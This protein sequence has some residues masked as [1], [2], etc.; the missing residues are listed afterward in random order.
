[1]LK[2]DDGRV[3]KPP[4]IRRRMPKHFKDLPYPIINRTREDATLIRSLNRSFARI[5]YAENCQ[6]YL[7]LK[8]V[9]VEIEVLSSKEIYW[10]LI[11]NS[12]IP[13]PYKQKWE[14]IFTNSEIN[15]NLV[16]KNVHDNILP[17]KVQSSLWEMINLNFICSYRLQR[18]YGSPTECI[19]CRKQEEGQTHV[20]IECDFSNSIP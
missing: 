18:M 5:Q 10:F 17:Y 13:L 16:W 2:D 14:T 4:G 8:G 12:M 19:Q 3:Y 1:M 11:E 15:W 6:F 7:L 20:F 9:K